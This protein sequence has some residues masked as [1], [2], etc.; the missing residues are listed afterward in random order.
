[1]ATV[2][3]ILNAND[4]GLVSW[5]VFVLGFT[6]FVSLTADTLGR[7]TRPFLNFRKRKE[8]PFD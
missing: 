7:L 2:A 6:I 5:I 1:M 3:P 8:E 4:P